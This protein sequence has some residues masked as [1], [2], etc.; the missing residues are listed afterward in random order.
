MFNKLILGF[1]LV[2]V[3]F[4]GFFV[5]ADENNGQNFQG[6]L[7]NL[8]DENQLTV[9]QEGKLHTKTDSSYR[10]NF[11][12]VLRQIEAIQDQI[13]VTQKAFFLQL[14]QRNG[15]VVVNR[16]ENIAGVNYTRN[17]ITEFGWFGKSLLD[18]RPA[19][20]IQP[21]VP[22]NIGRNSGYTDIRA[23]SVREKKAALA[24]YYGYYKQRSL[25]NKFY[26]ESLVQEILKG[27]L[28]RINYDLNRQVSNAGYNA[29]KAKVMRQVNLVYKK[30]SFSNKTYTIKIGKSLTL[31]DNN[32]SFSSYKLLSNNVN[33]FIVK[34]GNSIK[35]T[36]KKESKNQGNIVFKYDIDKNFQN[37]ALIYQAR[38][39]Q[40]VFIG[41][42]ADPPYFKININVQKNAPVEIEYR[43]RLDHS[44]LKHW[45][46]TKTIGERFTASPANP[47][48]VNGKVYIPVST[49]SQSLVV[50]ENGNKLVFYY[51]LQRTVTV[52]HID[53][54]TNE[55]I[56]PDVK[57]QKRRGE[58]YLYQARTDLKRNGLSYQ[59]LEPT[60]V[61]GTIGNDDVQVKFYYEAPIAQVD[62]KR[63]EIYTANAK[64]GLPVK[65]QLQ[66]K[67][68]YPSNLSLYD[69]DHVKL[70][71][72]A[73][74][75]KKVVKKLE[76]SVKDL[77][78]KIET[79][80][81]AEGLKKD[82]HQSYTVKIEG[83]K[84]NEII[85]HAEK[86]STDGYTASEKILMA[87]GGKNDAVDYRSVVMTGRNYGE[88]MEK[89]YETFHVNVPKLKKQKTGYGFAYQ[90]NSTYTNELAQSTTVR[91]N[92]VADK[93]LLDSYLPYKTTKKSVIVPLENT[94]HQQLNDKQDDTLELPEVEVERHTGALFTKQQVADK[95]KRI[96]RELR[97]G[98]RKFYVPIW[99]DL[100]DYEVD[101][102]TTQPIGVDEIQV[103][104]K[105][106]L[107]IKAYMFGTYGSKTIADDELVFSPANSQHPF[108]AGIPEN[109]T[110]QDV[111]WFKAGGNN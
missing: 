76:Y 2:L 13:H 93:T 80:I 95:D 79:L 41:G 25:V 73:D 27:Y 91:F 77:P 99:M 83:L 88:K 53:K 24:V 30:P 48:K 60:K 68:V 103:I 9:D 18:G 66:K 44:L 40:N 20:C 32:G 74:Q 57:E 59:P 90:L 10:E 21:G 110:E 62:L 43:D 7:Q 78:E 28:T 92:I 104:I 65:L 42:Y 37:P 94:K 71:I 107:P 15:V 12:T 84:D 23:T 64:K 29:F 105:N 35:I 8:L 46:E 14:N 101:S 5:Y 1:F 51:D 47:L 54:R 108:D 45:K 100:G 63:V 87:T 4:S 17:G 31:Y 6:Q 16:N 22:L 96:T 34:T 69:T 82:D 109:F 97:A 86:I 102:Q 55:K 52:S 58:K 49:K 39:L 70:V 36:P 81:P 61:S 72:Q 56:V 33:V 3:F 26:T 85:S 111:Q 98:G 19:F 38:Y 106:T 50:K 67:L 75:T 11:E 89:K